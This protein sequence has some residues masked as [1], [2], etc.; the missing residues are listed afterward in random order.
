MNIVVWIIIGVIVLGIISGFMNYVKKQEEEK[1][2]A[3]MNSDPKEALK[4]ITKRLRV[5]LARDLSGISDKG[6]YFT[7]CIDDYE[8]NLSK[9]AGNLIDEDDENRITAARKLQLLEVMFKLQELYEDKLYDSVTDIAENYS[10]FSSK[11]DL[12]IKALE[13]KKDMEKANEFIDYA[14]EL[15]AKMGDLKAIIDFYGFSDFNIN[16]NAYDE[17]LLNLNNIQP[18]SSDEESDKKYRIGIVYYKTGK[19][20]DAKKLFMPVADKDNKN[21]F[22][23]ACC[24]ERENNFIQVDRLLSEL[25]RDYWKDYDDTMM[26]SVYHNTGIAYFTGNQ[27]VKKDINKAVNYY[28][29]AALLGNIKS[30][31]VMGIFMLQGEIDGT[32]VPR[33]Y[34]KINEYLEKAKIA[35][36][37]QAIDTLE[38]YGVDDIIVNTATSKSVTYKF[39]DGHKLTAPLETIKSLQ[40]M[41][42]LKYK[43][44]KIADAFPVEYAN[45]ITSFDELMN[46]IHLLYTYHVAQMLQWSVKLLMC[47]GIDSYDADAVLDNCEDLSLLPRVPVFEQG[48]D[49]IDNRAEELNIKLAY[50]QATRGKW[51]GGG[52]G[53]TISGTIAASIKG[54]IAA[55]AMNVGSG[56][57]YG[58]KDS[59]AG[60]IGN[61]EIKG[62]TKKLFENPNTIVEFNNAVRS[63]CLDVGI[64]VQEIIEHHTSIKFMGVKSSNHGIAFNHSLNPFVY[65]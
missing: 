52:F 4:E 39:M 44:F 17:I 46:G 1:F 61:A 6:G 54:S 32:V 36:I 13:K 49:R 10:I 58:I 63:A 3:L 42:G 8:K 29:K 2:K 45:N 7:S 30:M 62:M 26:G 22:M 53:T 16:S 5:E 55:G 48:L 18:Q 27:D 14:N 47:Y 34:F 31:A 25:E 12:L 41:H 11:K 57:L 59:I 60:A 51:V 56:I 40:L 50:A 9:V 24:F 19:Y 65:R 28:R 23:L 43:A 15:K 35:G 64:A 21:K 38:Q 33:D 20:D 37:Q